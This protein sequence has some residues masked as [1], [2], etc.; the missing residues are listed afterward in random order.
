[1]ATNTPADFMADLA[2][3]IQRLKVE[4]NQKVYSIGIE[5]FLRIVER[6]PSPTNKGYFAKGLLVNQWY[7][8]DGPSFSSNLGSSISPNGADSVARIKALRGG[9]QFVGKD[10]KITL[11]NNVPYAYQA[12]MLGWAAT[13]PYRMVALSLQ[14]VAARHK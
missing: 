3:N 4:V 9:I 5:L 6:T 2:R 14:E 7:P 12:E 11:V 10:G 8:T 1:M 13:G